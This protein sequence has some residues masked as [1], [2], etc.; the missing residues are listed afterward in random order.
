M[1]GTEKNLKRKLK[2]KTP[3][4]QGLFWR[5]V[6]NLEYASENAENDDMKS[7]W[8]IKL[9]QLMLNVYEY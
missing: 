4:Q 7:M 1:I 9:F 8:K 2:M 6:S 5:R 3:E